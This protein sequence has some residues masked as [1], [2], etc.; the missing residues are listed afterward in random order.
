MHSYV[1]RTVVRGDSQGL[2]NKL[3]K[4]LQDGWARIGWSWLDNLDLRNIISA[5]FK[6]LDGNQ[7]DAWY[8]HGFVDRAQLGDLLFYPNVPDFGQ[9]SIVKITGEYEFLSADNS[10]DG[11]LRSARKCELQTEKGVSKTDAIVAPVLRARLDLQGR[12][13]RV[14]ADEEITDLLK[15]IPEAGVELASV[16]ASMDKMLEEAAK[17]M[18]AKWSRL[19]PQKD[20]SKMLEQLLMDRGDTVEYKEGSG[21]KGADL[22]VTMENE[23]LKEP[24]LIGVQVGSYADKVWPN[25]VTEKL[26]QLLSGWEANKLNYGALVLAGRCENDAHAI[27]NQ[28]NKDN[29]AKKVV[30]LDGHDLALLAPASTSASVAKF[31]MVGVWPL[32]S[33]S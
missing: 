10:I 15:R 29:P 22:I 26:N 20:L 31:P 1:V 17:S 24:I 18:E 11:D 27:V 33:G 25:T 4:S 2:G 12:F 30:L 6:N 3:F 9:F 13:Y 8:C 19:F 7:Q 32:L 16:S 23:F 5:D 14:Y 28:H 21:E